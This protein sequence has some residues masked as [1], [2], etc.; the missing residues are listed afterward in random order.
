MQKDNQ[1]INTKRPEDFLDL[2]RREKRGRLKV[3]LGSAAGVGKTYRM[4]SEGQ[5]LKESGIDVAIGYLEPHE[6]AETIAQAEGLEQIPGLMVPHGKLMLREMDLDAVI[7][8]HPNVA[9]IDELAHTNTPDSKNQKRYQDV[10]AL[11]D[12]GINVITTLNV[13]HLESLYNI[14]E[15][16]TGIKVSERIPDAVVAKADQ[17]ID[18]DLEAEDL[19]ERLK[20]GK[21][22]K[23]DRVDA[24]LKNFFSLPNLNRLREIALSETAN[25]LD[26]RQREKFE[27]KVKPSALNKIMVRIRGSESKSESEAVLRRASRLASQ[28]NADWYLVHVSTVKNE[29][30]LLSPEIENVSQILELARKMGAETIEL[31]DE[32]V[33]GALIRFARANGITHLVQSHASPRKFW[34]VFRKSHTEVLIQNLPDVQIIMV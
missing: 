7:K 11:L 24:A 30:R 33:P 1:R 12:A 6:R 16:A 18:V 32:D 19:I 5:R 21:I 14:V 3:Y 26:K 25:L 23:L 4:L 27:V 2:I 34:Q 31:K 29:S 15:D 13:Q 28:L 9:L 10:E 20:S 22:Y 8:R 17:I